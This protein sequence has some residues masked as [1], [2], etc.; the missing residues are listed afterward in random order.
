M[1]SVYVIAGETT[2]DIVFNVNQN[3]DE[4]LENSEGLSKIIIYGNM[5]YTNNIRIVDPDNNE[6]SVP[7]DAVRRF[8]KGE[9]L[10]KD[11]WKTYTLNGEPLVLE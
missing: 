5:S 4:L 10:D 8:L 1:S 9:L 7:T 6:F 2:D 3:I 11:L